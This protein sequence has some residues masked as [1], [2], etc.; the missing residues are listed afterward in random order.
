[1][2]VFSTAA[3][4][5]AQHEGESSPPAGIDDRR[6][7]VLAGL[8]QRGLIG[9]RDRETLKTLLNRASEALD[10]AICKLAI[11]S[12]ETLAE[13]LADIFQMEQLQGSAGNLDLSPASRMS[14][15]F[16]L[17]NRVCPLQACG[18][19]RVALA[20]PTDL[21]GLRGCAFALETD[22]APLLVTGSQ[23]EAL[24]ARI[25]PQEPA[26]DEPVDIANGD[27]ERL[28]DLASAE[29]AVRLCYRLVAE[30]ARA[31]ASDIHFE[32]AEREY[33]VRFR[34][35]GQLLDRE[36]LSVKQGLAVVSRLKI[37]S[38]LDIAERRRPQDGRFTFPVA[39]RAVDLRISATPNVHGEGVVLRLLQRADI[40]LDLQALGFAAADARRLYALSDRPNGILLLTGPTGSGKTTTLY[41][42][43]QRLAQRESKILTIEDP[44]EYRLDGVSQTQ[45]NPDIGLDFATALRSFLRHDPDII[46]VG[47]MR[48]LETAR[49]A[50]QAALTGHLVLSTLHTNDAP[51]A[52]V[53]LIDMGVEDYLVASTLIGVV[54]QRLVRRTCT[55]CDGKTGPRDLNAPVC[56]TCMGTGFHGRVAIAEV[57]ET[58]DGLRA[59]IKRNAGSAE[60]IGAARANGFRTMREDGEA[61]IASGLTTTP[62]VLK[63]VVA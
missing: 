62:E 9:A 52:I 25:A 30:A 33:R 61:K 19:I 37:L 40:A 28:R 5:A 51:S 29:P 47:E 43:L 26:E 32:P 17:R 44:V 49:T 22:V 34:I 8:A 45:V 27:A 4:S 39:G 50:I 35:D 14:F 56:P 60:L 1:M 46:M 10:L 41:A 24:L 36:T 20:D 12:E 11:M 57:L 6:R 38:N 55:A 48:D 16:L 59:A 63:A 53:R 2:S 54:G 42:L 21:T 15:T 23:I 7:L 18:A 3:S 58:D 13:L 31:R